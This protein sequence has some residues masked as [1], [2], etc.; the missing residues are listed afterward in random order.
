MSKISLEERVIEDMA[1]M[2]DY[3]KKDGE[4]PAVLFFHFDKVPKK[5]A[6]FMNKMPEGS[7]PVKDGF[8]YAI[9]DPV[10]MEYRHSFLKHLATVFAALNILKV[11]EDPK[12]L[13]FCAE[14]FASEASSIKD[15][16]RVR[17]S[18]D[19]KAKDVFIAS[20]ITIEGEQFAKVKEKKLKMVKKGKNSLIETEL[21]ALEP[22]DGLNMVHSPIL[23]SFFKVLKQTKVEMIKDKKIEDFA[24]LA[25]ENPVEAFKQ[26]FAA[27]IT[28]T[29]LTAFKDI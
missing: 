18:E 23:E 6:N 25:S 10:L 12:Q 15:A 1:I 17:P 24:E 9:T 21:V 7:M 14:A 8:F 4:I 5:I 11:I 29:Q 22:E 28:M 20:G 16:K 3:M 19:P 2:E 27:A 13:I 26:A